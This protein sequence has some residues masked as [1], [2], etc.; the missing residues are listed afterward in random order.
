MA[1]VF[2]Q[3]HRLAEDHGEQAIAFERQEEVFGVLAE[4][5]VGHYT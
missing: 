4:A 5:A 2:G 3:Q 1:L